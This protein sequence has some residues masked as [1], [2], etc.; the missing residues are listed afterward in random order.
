MEIKTLLI[1]AT[2]DHKNRGWGN[3]YI[4]VPPEHP[5]YGL[6]DM[7]PIIDVI[8]VHGGITYGHSHAPGF[9]PDGYWWIGFDTAH[10]QDNPERCPCEYVEAQTEQLKQ[11]AIDAICQLPS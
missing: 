2:W 3:G 10:Y 8:E 4:G 7:T 5:R 9:E 6:D 11:Q 1:P